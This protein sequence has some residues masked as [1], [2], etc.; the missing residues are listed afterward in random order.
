MKFKV[1]Y[2]TTNF[3]NNIFFITHLVFMCA[4]EAEAEAELPK[5]ILYKF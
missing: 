1:G 3:R 4:A 5:E 2:K